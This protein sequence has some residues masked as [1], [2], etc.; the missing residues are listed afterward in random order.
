MEV[1]QQSWNEPCNFTNHFTII[2]CKLKRLAKCIA[3]WAKN[4]IGDIRR[5]M[6]VG[7]E[8]ILRLDTAQES[9]QLSVDEKELRSSL[10]AREVGL[11]AINRIK[12]RQRA[13][14]KWLKLG[15]ANTKYFHSRATHRK[16][17]IRIQS[18]QSDNGIATSPLEIEEVVF[19]H[20]TKIMGTSVPC[21]ERFRWEN[22]GLSAPD[23]SEL[24][25]VFT[26][27]EVKSAV[28]DSP[29]ERA[30]GPDGFSGGFFKSS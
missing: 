29:V 5:Q 22:L 12:A 16:Q 20:M 30:P 28:F 18:L 8:I 13:R 2:D 6:L 10:K 7:Q 27:Q 3:T 21:A 24:D 1:V 26:M 23:L 14:I 9:R 15:D 4:Y 11:A 17:K 25:A 19:E